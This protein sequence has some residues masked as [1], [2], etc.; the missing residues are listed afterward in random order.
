MTLVKK[1]PFVILVQMII[2]LLLEISGNC[3]VGK[4]PYELLSTLV[5]VEGQLKGG[6]RISS[7]IF[8][9]QLKPSLRIH[10]RLA[11]GKI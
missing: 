10:V 3:H 9:H 4:L 8:W 7:D 11:Y 6:R 1:G 5:V 2:W